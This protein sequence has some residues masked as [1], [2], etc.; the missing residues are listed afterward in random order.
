MESELA[1]GYSELFIRIGKDT[2][3]STDMWKWRDYIV[4]ALNISITEL[5][6]IRFYRYLPCMLLLIS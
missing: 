1:F 4:P 2:Q 5:P 6:I 3:S